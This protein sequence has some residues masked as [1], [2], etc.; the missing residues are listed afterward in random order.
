MPGKKMLITV[1]VIT[2]VL[3][4]I[5]LV[6]GIGL[7]LIGGL[8]RLI[9]GPVEFPD[10]EEIMMIG[11]AALFVIFQYIPFGLMIIGG[12]LTISA[13]I[14]LLISGLIACF[15]DYELVKQKSKTYLLIISAILIG[16][17]LLPSILLMISLCLSD[18][19]IGAKIAGVFF[20]LIINSIHGLMLGFIFTARS[21]ILNYKEEVI[22]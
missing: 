1:R 2:K 5:F 20:I 14:H 10:T 7:L 13:L 19:G 18:N 15:N 4:I 17:I 9:I 8:L 11:L 3:G 12:I 21:R 6:G 22:I 16:I